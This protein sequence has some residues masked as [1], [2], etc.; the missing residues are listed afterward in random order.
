MTQQIAISTLMI[1]LCLLTGC[2]VA[3]LPA[4]V[5]GPPITVCEAALRRVGARILVRGEFGGFAYD[6]ESRN[7]TIQG[8]GL[9]A[10]SRCA[11]RR[12]EQPR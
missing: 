1:S 12:T 9:C 2:S 10:R 8:E 7:V 6:T 11:V 4:Q 5:D 3:A